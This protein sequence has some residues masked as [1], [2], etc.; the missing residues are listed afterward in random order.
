MILPLRLSGAFI[1]DISYGLEVE[2]Q[3]DV[4][5][6]Q[7]E[8]GMAAMAAAGTG[9]SYVVDLMPSLKVLPSWFPGVHFKKDAA[10]WRPHVLAM[11][12]EPLKYVEDRL[13]SCSCPLDGP[14]W[15]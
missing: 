6:T 4:F 8:R 13:V 5:I 1:L 14:T 11:A 7:A 9:I 2:S 12:R 15:N 10:A 3:D